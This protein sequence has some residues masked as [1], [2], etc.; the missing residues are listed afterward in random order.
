MVFTSRMAEE[1]Q[2][3]VGPSPGE[4]VGVEVVAVRLLDVENVGAE[5]ETLE[6]RELAVGLGRVGKDEVAKETMGVVSRD[7]RF[8]AMESNVGAD[9]EGEESITYI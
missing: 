8:K 1:R 2:V 3:R 7:A 4:G 6:T 5:H 9:H